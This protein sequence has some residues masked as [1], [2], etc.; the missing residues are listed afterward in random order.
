M[1]VSSTF[2]KTLRVLLFF[3]ILFILIKMAS[4]F[5]EFLG[6]KSVG[7]VQDR[8]TNVAGI[9]VEAENTIDVLVLGDS[10][11]YT[12]VSPMQLFD[13]T[14]ITS[15][16]CG[17]SAQRIIETYHVL[18]TALQTQNPKLV[19]IETNTFF[20]HKGANEEASAETFENLQYQF[21][22]FR[23]HNLWKQL[24]Y[25]SS[26]TR[27]DYKGFVIRD[28]SQAYTGGEYMHPSDKEREVN[29]HICGYMDKI[30]ELC[31]ENDIQIL[32]YSAPSPKNY[33]SAK[34]NGLQKFADKYGVDY[35]D[36][37]YA[38]ED[39]GINW[40]TD[41]ADKG[42]HLNLNGAQKV[43]TYIGSF[44]KENYSLEDH[45][46]TEL[47]EVWNKLVDAYKNDIEKREEKLL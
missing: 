33:N 3:V 9:Q 27:S 15:Y 14:G 6:K 22:L 8:N 42:D 13:E 10:E 7:K 23:Y 35:I 12:S 39:L 47:G 44:L 26:D 34:H 28:W 25:G 43:T 2:K 40:K 19:M 1:Q 32:L 30:V 41:T 31:K 4:F 45:R 37:N 24:F 21:Q 16:I 18:E 5:F 17:Q 11:S 38:V 46:G 29:E 20:R 36:L